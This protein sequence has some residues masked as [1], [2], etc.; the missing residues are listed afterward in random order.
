MNKP[1]GAMYAMCTIDFNYLSPE[2]DSSSK[3][4]ELLAAEEGLLVL[5]S[6]CFSATG[7]FRIVICNPV[8]VLEEAMDRIQAFV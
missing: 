2:V 5:P 7:S 4:C 3:F 6:E 8:E 1:K